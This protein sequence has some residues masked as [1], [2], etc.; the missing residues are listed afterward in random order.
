MNRRQLLKDAARA[1]SLANLFFLGAWMPMID[2]SFNQRLKFTLFNFNNLFAL[3]LNILLLAAVFWG[4]VI[5][6]RASKR[7]LGMHVVRSLFLLVCF[8]LLSLPWYSQ[9]TWTISV[10]YF[11]IT[12]W[13]V[14]TAI[15]ITSF[16]ILMKPHLWRWL[17]VT[18][19]VGILIWSG[20]REAYLAKLSVL[21]LFG[22]LIWRW[23]RQMVKGA[24]ILSLLLFPFAAFLILQNAWLIYKLQNQTPQPMLA[25]P[26][27]TT[28][29]V[30]WMIFDE[31]DYRA[32]FGNSSA[33][34]PLPEFTRLQAQSLVA[35]NAYPPADSTMLSLPAFITGRLTVRAKPIHSSEL[36]LNFEDSEDYVEWST[37][38]N[39]FMKA[40]EVGANSGMVGWY[41]PYRRVIGHTLNR[42]TVSDA[43]EL[44]L[45]VS[46]VLNVNRAVERTW[47]R[48]YSMPLAGRLAE[49]SR[50]RH[51]ESYKEI[52]D[53]AKR[54]AIHPDLGLVLIHLPVP[55]PP[56]IYN[57]QVSEFEDLGQSSYFDNLALADRTLSEI[58]QAMEEAGLWEDSVILVSSDHWWRPAIWQSLHVWTE[59]DQHFAPPT[60]ESDYRVPFLLKMPG[61]KTHIAYDTQFNTV[62]SQALLIEILQGRVR[63]VDGVKH[64][65][66]QK[67]STTENPY[68]W[69]QSKN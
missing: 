48:S 46:M 60:G 2:T 51:I 64:W 7:E 24:A 67:A 33:A 57:R 26:S 17:V 58:R 20:E 37:H 18:S 69:D 12:E 43:D 6:A 29:R 10:G 28:K 42:C 39:V 61:Q 45:P 53:E 47:I 8:A 25:Q 52:L 5:L 65:L 21:L 38:P 3:I 54:L 13:R 16:F 56:G 44:S 50:Q 27:L 32:A 1:L 30:V 49:W 15:S 35:S 40:R 63:D 4:G 68:L 41:H 34:V 11:N 31:M 66:D 9:R 23:H 14:I 59:E 19:A 36:L 22:G 62:H 55:H